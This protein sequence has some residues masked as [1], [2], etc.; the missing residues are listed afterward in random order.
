MARQRAECPG[1]PCP[2]R[3]GDGIPD[4][5]DTD[6]DGPDGGDADGDGIPDDAECAKGVPC[7]D[8]DGDGVPDYLDVD[9]SD[10]AI[11]NYVWLDANGDGMQDASEAPAVG[12]VVTLYG[13]NTLAVSAAS[14]GQ[15]AVATLTTGALGHYA[16]QNL[17][18]GSYY[19]EI[20]GANGL[21]PTRPNQGSDDA[22]DSD[23]VQVGLTSVGR[24]PITQLA[25]QE[26]QFGWDAGLTA[27]V[28]VTG[29][30]FIDK[31][32]NQ[33]LDAD[34][35]TVPG[36]IVILYDEQLN[37]VARVTSNSSGAYSFANLAPGHYLVGVEPPNGLQRSTDGLQQVPVLTPGSNTTNLIPLFGNPTAIALVSLWGMLD[38]GQI[39]VHWS[40]SSELNT[41]GY[42]VYLGENED[43][44][45]ATKMNTAFIHSQGEFGGNYRMTFAVDSDNLPNRLFVWL[46]E[47]EILGHTNI[48]GPFAVRMS[49]NAIYLPLLLRQ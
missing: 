27:P 37:I 26:Q 5:L 14:V 3:D 38:D 44:T 45:R 1:T 39:V 36:A 40:T 20:E 41:L 15:N 31:N 2:D 22:V 23:A 29:V 25:S 6:D 47:T 46:V 48:Y 32:R 19:V 9:G 33:E 34:E 4:Y 35:L 16:F 49:Q 10:T 24:M 12:I 13:A 17:T 43:L 8:S 18:A 30:V 11:G 7:P 21:A 28:S 42:D